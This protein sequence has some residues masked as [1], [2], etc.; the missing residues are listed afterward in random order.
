MG[1]GPSTPPPSPDEAIDSQTLTGHPVRGLRSSN[2]HGIRRGAG[3]AECVDDEVSVPEEITLGHRDYQER[4]EW[5]GYNP[6]LPCVYDPSGY[7]SVTSNI[8]EADDEARG[9][10]DGAADRSQGGIN[11]EHFYSA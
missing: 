3:G 4:R 7:P 1:S 10:L 2:V 8:W 11:L 9:D 6:R 5:P